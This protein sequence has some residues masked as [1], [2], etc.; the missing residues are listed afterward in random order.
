MANFNDREVKVGAIFGESV[1]RLRKRHLFTL[2]LFLVPCAGF[3]LLA[4]TNDDSKPSISSSDFEQFLSRSVPLPSPL[5]NHQGPPI[6]HAPQ[7]GPSTA[8]NT[9]QPESPQ[10]FSVYPSPAIPQVATVGFSSN[11][12]AVENYVPPESDELNA[13]QWDGAWWDALGSRSNASRPLITRN[14][15]R[16]YYADL[17]QMIWQSMQFSYKIQSILKVPKIQSTE[18]DIARGDLDPRP[19]AQSTFRDTSDPVGNTL[20]TGGPNRLNEY[21][22]E[23]SVGIRDRNSYG[24]RTEFGQA[25]NARDSNSLFFVP[26]NQVDSKLTLNYTQPLMRGA[27]L[28]YNTSS[29]RLN[30]IK[31]QEAVAL[32]N[33][34]LQDHA[35]RI[36]SEYWEL[37]LDRYHFVQTINAKDRFERRREQL[38][39]RR[40]R[41]LLDMYIKR[42]EYMIAQQDSQ[43]EL[44]RAEIRSHHAELARLVGAPEIQRTLCDELIPLTPPVVSLPPADSLDDELYNA[45]LYR[46]DIQ[47][48]RFQIDQA[49]VN[50]NLAVNELKPTLDAILEGYV[51]GLAGDK[52]LLNSF[53]RQFDSGA[54]SYAAGFVYQN[55]YRNRAAKANLTGRTIDFKKLIDDYEDKVM[56]AESQVC[57]AIF[58][59]K[60][61]F[62]AIHAALNATQA[63]QAEVDHHETRLNDYFGE[64]GSPSSILNELLDAENRLLSAEKELA[65]RQIE[66]MQALTQI[67]YESGT[68]LTLTQE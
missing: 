4:E 11:Q 16:I 29:I 10:P 66:H 56:Q 51:R 53:S 60:G 57:S 42:A 28:Y 50:R 37:V 2:P 46:G 65:T 24:G 39:N 15:D 26:K 12:P 19:F 58:K 8:V 49:A 22:W 67:K 43:K 30:E 25:M 5:Q 34:E 38:E 62:K 6:P 45:M 23:N 61:T 14:K 63:A 7:M 17:E 13:F 36:H 27:G 54:P 52:R 41:D 47:A 59:A 18:I 64:N 21:F 9:F 55:P 32:A 48:V 35:R 1:R 3:S 33:Q 44:L 31:T 40:G 68:L 20:T